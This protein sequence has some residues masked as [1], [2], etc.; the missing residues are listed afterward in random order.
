M[1]KVWAVWTYIASF[2]YFKV[3]YKVPINHKAQTYVYCANH[4]SYMDI[5]TLFLAIPG[6]FNILGK[7]ELGKVPLFGYMYRKLYISVN[8]HSPEARYKSYIDALDSLDQNRSVAFYPEGKIPHNNQHPKMGDFKDGPFKAAIEK[9]IPIIPITIPYNW[10]ILPDKSKNT[11]VHWHK[12]GIIF[13][14]P[15]ETKGLTLDDVTN[16]KNRVYQI[17]DDELTKLNK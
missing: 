2:I 8:R 5:P 6:Y 16:L 1:N 14:K 15:I 10:I 17:M 4:T 3:E 13:H 9:Q 12:C 7:A 11:R